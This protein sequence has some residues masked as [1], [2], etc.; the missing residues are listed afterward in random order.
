[1]TPFKQQ[2]WN[3]SYKVIK[4]LADSPFSG[5][6]LAYKEWHDLMRDHMLTAKQGYGR[7]LWEVEREKMPLT[8]HRQMIQPTLKG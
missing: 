7:V 5:D 2:D 6:I 1:M 3:I 8:F 4:D